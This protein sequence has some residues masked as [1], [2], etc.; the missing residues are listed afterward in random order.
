MFI[1]ETS[2]TY[3]KHM[4]AIREGIEDFEYLRILNDRITYLEK[5]GKKDRAIA[6]AKELLASGPDRV[7]AIMTTPDK[8]NWVE[9]KDRS[10]ADQVRIEIL[11]ALMGLREL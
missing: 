6:S 4:E 10:L 3:G 11:E 1:D 8:I 5:N 9:S 7:I 2:V